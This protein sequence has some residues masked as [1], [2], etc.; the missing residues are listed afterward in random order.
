M[1]YNFGGYKISSSEYKIPTT[2]SIDPPTLNGE[3]NK[4]YTFT[5][6]VDN[7][8]SGAQYQWS[9][10]GKP[11][12]NGADNS[13]K[14]KFPDAAGTVSYTIAVSLLDGKGKEIDSAKATANIAKAATPSTTDTPSGSGPL[15][16]KL[17]NCTTMSFDMDVSLIMTPSTLDKNTG[18]WVDSTLY[19]DDNCYCIGKPTWNGSSFSVHYK[20]GD[21]TGTVSSDGTKIERLTWKSPA[22]S[23]SSSSYTLINLNL[24]ASSFSDYSGKHTLIKAKAGNP[25]A[26]N[27]QDMRPCL[28][29]AS[30]NISNQY[31]H[32]SG[33]L[34]NVDWTQKKYS[35]GL[36]LTFDCPAN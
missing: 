32:V 27:V 19:Y 8:P 3:P 15:L 22:T 10:N 1:Y 2:V 21:I 26:I 33:S 7:P 24:T 12:Q 36:D 31:Y 6:K 14:T 35:N 28:T 13:M 18:K 11:V 20:D 16:A 25:T 9:V 5:A 23:S 4:D 29:S 30:F 17:Q 34:Q